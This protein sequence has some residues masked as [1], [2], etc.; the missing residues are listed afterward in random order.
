MKIRLKRRELFLSVFFSVP[1]L[2]SAQPIVWTTNSLVRTG[3]NDSARSGAQATISAAGGEYESFQIAIQAP[4]GGL[5]NVNVSVTD[6]V[7]PGGAI[8]PRSSFSL[9]REHY[10]YVSQ[11]SPNWGGSNQPQGAGWYPDALIPF[12]DQDSGRPIQGAQIQAVPFN[13]QASTNQPIWVDI[14]VPRGTVAGQYSGWYTVT[15]DQGNNGGPIALTVWNFTLPVQS[16][17]KTAFLAYNST[18]LASEKELLRNKISPLHSDPANQTS[19]MT[20]YGLSTVGLPYY[21]GATFENCTMGLPPSIGD[22]L[23]LLAAQQPGLIPLIYS[24]DETTYCPA[25]TPLIKLWAQ[26]LHAAG[27]KNLVTMAPNSALFDDGTGSGRSAVDIWSVLP[28]GY[29]LSPSLDAAALAKGDAIW[30]YNALV[31]DAYSPKWLIDF[32]PVNYRI[33]PGFISQSLGLTGMM[34]WKVDSWSSDPWNQVNNIGL[35][36]AGNY[37]GEG[38]LVYPGYQVGIDGVAPSMRLKWLRDGVEDYEYVQ[39]LKAA[40]QGAFALQ[41]AGKV[42]P[43]WTYWSQ[44]PN[45]L[46]NVREQL[47]QQL[48]QVNGGSPA[49]TAPSTPAQTATCSGVNVTMVQ[50]SVWAA[51]QVGIPQTVQVK[52][53]DSCAAIL[54]A[55]NGGSA[56]VTFDNGDPAVTL[57]DWG[58]G[59]WTGS[60]TP[61]NPGSQVSLTISAASAAGSGSTHIAV[62]VQPVARQGTVKVAVDA[63][64]GSQAIP[65][66]VTAGSY[67]SIYG[68][69]LAG[70]PASAITTPLPTTLSGAQVFI[71]PSQMTL[72]YA[73][74]N[75]INGVVPQGLTPG[76]T[77]PLVVIN[78][79]YSS[80]PISVTIAS[81]QPA[82]YSLDA[83]GSGQGIIQI[84]GTTS[85]SSAF[86]AGA[87]PATQGEY[88]TIYC[89][90]LGP[91]AGP[92]GE[93]PPADGS[94][95][96]LDMAFRTLGDVTVSIGGIH[97]TAQFAGLAPGLVGVYQVNVRVPSDGLSGDAIPVAIMMTNPQAGGFVQSNTVTVA[98]R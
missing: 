67:I 65:G 70:N 52:A 17:L 34:Y 48:N 89:N 39:M 88:L 15:S 42:G 2:A 69:N 41:L 50:P 77:Y 1:F 68:T 84:A 9:F 18:N 59:I 95:A 26:N 79:G 56:V 71:G 27:I 4:P 3:I 21:S 62:N 29:N 12:T 38:M 75:Q 45:Q 60:W 8:I 58:N 36:S 86:G 55:A 83:S 61:V 57:Q 22:L 49:T 82:I 91:V 44:D 97:Q 81:V 98:L 30:S 87:R 47:G 72:V 90:G 7:G 76:A 11:S 37:P 74:S 96:P 5:T 43:D 80:D 54:A 40:G 31:Q 16:S 10:V 19:L 94:A 13:L 14:L 46:L 78:G 73:A 24:A 28:Y 35:Y 53:V 6:L 23:A 33:Q 32:A 85:M 20:N 92:N 63:A 51:L 25:L 93:P 64:A 66:L